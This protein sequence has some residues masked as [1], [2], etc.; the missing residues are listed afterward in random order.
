[1]IDMNIIC[2]LIEKASNVGT[3]VKTRMV[4]ITTR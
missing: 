2:E 3:A 1:M 4:Y